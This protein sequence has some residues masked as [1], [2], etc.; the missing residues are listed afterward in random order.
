MRA[1][2]APPDYDLIVVGATGRNGFDRELLH[3][4]ADFADTL[5]DIT[6][7]AFLLGGVH[8]CTRTLARFVGCG[9]QPLA[10]T[11]LPDMPRDGDETTALIERFVTRLTALTN[12]AVEVRLQATPLGVRTTHFDA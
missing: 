9:W 7:G 2:P 8:R 10:T 5:D 3:W 4:I 1:M 6:S 11:L 12:A